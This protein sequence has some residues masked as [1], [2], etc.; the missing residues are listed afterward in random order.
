V[1]NPALGVVSTARHLR[2]RPPDRNDAIDDKVLVH[3]VFNFVVAMGG[4]HPLQAASM[5]PWISSR[6]TWPL[7]KRRDD[8]PKLQI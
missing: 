8:I 7:D 1:A 4:G 6:V 5:K 2:I 3:S